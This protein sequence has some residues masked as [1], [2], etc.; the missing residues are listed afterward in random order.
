M[1]AAACLLLASAGCGLEPG[2]GLCTEPEIELADMSVAD[3]TEP[4]DMQVTVTSDGEP[5]AGVE[6]SFYVHRVRDDGEE[7]ARRTGRA[8][9]DSEGVATH[10]LERGARDL[11]VHS[12]EEVIGYSVGFI[13]T[14]KLDGVQYCRSSVFAEL[15]VPCGGFACED[16]F[17][18][19]FFEG[20][21]G[22]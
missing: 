3:E 16:E 11:P 2:S 9:T 21:E 5:L 10:T 13:L 15:S 19:E 17:E 7:R 1:A 8:E 6:L 20:D 14:T 18:D 12:D 4:F 22:S